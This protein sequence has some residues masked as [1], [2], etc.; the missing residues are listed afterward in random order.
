MG[1]AQHRRTP[2]RRLEDINIDFHHITARV[3][4]GGLRLV[5]VVYSFAASRSR[6]HQTGFARRTLL[7]A[8]PSGGRR[9]PLPRGPTHLS[10]ICGPERRDYQLVHRGVRRN[11]K[12][13]MPIQPCHTGATGSSTKTVVRV[14]LS[15]SP[16]PTNGLG[17]ESRIW[18]GHH[19]ICYDQRK[20]ASSDEFQEQRR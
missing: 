7:F 10:Q 6:V 12:T 11:W 18:W 20:H 17:K 16:P 4:V 15:E 9:H 19:S 5:A 8:L 13:P 14:S 2:K 1:R 3:R